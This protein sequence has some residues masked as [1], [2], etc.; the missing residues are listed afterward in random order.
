M[1][2]AVRCETREIGSWSDFEGVIQNLSR[3]Q[4]ERAKEQGVRLP[5]LLFRGLGSSEWGLET[6]LERSYRVERCDGTLSLRKYYRK[7]RTAKPAIETLSGRR[8]ERVPTVPCFDK[9]LARNASLWLDQVLFQ[10][11]EIYEYLV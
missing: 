7:A 11:P 9:L 10:K 6:T 5:E 1:P 8:F 2:P 3:G 4:E